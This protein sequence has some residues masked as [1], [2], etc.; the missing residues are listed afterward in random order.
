MSTARTAVPGHDAPPEA[1]VAPLVAVTPGRRRTAA[2]EARTL[3]ASTSIGSLATLSSGRNPWASVVAYG[4]LPDGAPV[5]FVSTLAEHGRNLRRDPRTSLSVAEQA[6]AGDPLDSGRVTLAGRA[7]RPEG[8][9]AEQAL[10][11]HVAAVP[12]ATAY[13]AFGDFSLWVLRVERVRWV[14]GFGRMDSATAAEYAAAE[15][16]PTAPG[17]AGAVA[18]LNDDHADAL[19]AMA[20]GLAGH[21]DATAARCARIDRYGLDLAIAGPRG[22]AT[23]RVG[24]EHPAAHPGDLRAATIELTRRARAAL[25]PP[26]P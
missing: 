5:L 11:A 16:D 10:A 25:P 3:V 7:E 26:T 8:E 20:H 23:A 13:A 21:P 19:L 22:D 6:P 15:P 1:I 14:G 18:H 9:L 2:E 12:G 17:A 24:F 4:T